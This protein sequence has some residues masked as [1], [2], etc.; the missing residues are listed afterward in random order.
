VTLS[1]LSPDNDDNVQRNQ[2]RKSRSFIYSLRHLTFARRK[3]HNKKGNHVENG[4]IS[5]FDNT[6]QTNSIAHSV[7]AG[8]TH[9]FYNLMCVNE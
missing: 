1:P 3:K 8:K 4:V 6:I 7:S 5:P 9:V 2:P